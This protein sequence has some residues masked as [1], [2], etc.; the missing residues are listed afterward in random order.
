MTGFT[1]GLWA[2]EASGA[3]ALLRTVPEPEPYFLERRFEAFRTVGENVF[4]QE[5]VDY[6]RG[7]IWMTDG[8]VDG[9][10]LVSEAVEGDANRSAASEQSYFFASFGYGTQSLYSL[11]VD[12]GEVMLLGTWE[13]YFWEDL[14]LYSGGSSRVY[15]RAPSDSG[16]GLW[17]TDGTPEGTIEVRFDRSPYWT[18]S[19]AYV[20]F[21]DAFVFETLGGDEVPVL[22]EHDALE[23][24][25]QLLRMPP[26][27]SRPWRGPPTVLGDLLFFF[28]AEEGTSGHQLWRTDG[29]TAGTFQVSQFPV[30]QGGIGTG[31]GFDA[32]GIAVFVLDHYCTSIPPHCSWRNYV[33]DGSVE[34]SGL[35]EGDLEPWTAAAVP[36][37]VLVPGCIEG[38][39]T[40]LELA[41]IDREDRSVR[42]AANFEPEIGATTFKRLLAREG[43]LYLSTGTW[44]S[45]PLSWFLPSPL[46]EPI[47]S[48]GL[49]RGDAGGSGESRWNDCRERLLRQSTLHLGPERGELAPPS[50]VVRGLWRRAGEGRDSWRTRLPSRKRDQ[51]GGVGNE[52]DGRG[53]A[54]SNRARA[55][56]LR[57]DRRCLRLASVL[58]RA[59]QFLELVVASPV[60]RHPDSA[61]RRDGPAVL[62]SGA[63]S[64][65]DRES[66]LLHDARV[67]VVGTLAPFGRDSGGNRHHLDLGGERARARS[68]PGR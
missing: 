20:W 14:E 45:E 9:T 21:G 32:G 68:L 62:S 8:T 3:A 12:S 19:F 51:P 27:D 4:F 33:S 22:W 53:D 63:R 41:L 25:A 16:T 60:G 23:P 29:T 57:R 55:S 67:R 1:H 34:G 64:G 2:V 48:S 61:L 54:G 46:Q 6:S 13:A 11:N 31:S 35:V 39:P 59:I 28:V 30:G 5:V 50:P 47:A 43:E 17:V 37:G 66:P 44:W 65:H 42:V 36:A 26:P 15:F 40:G 18:E 7:R 49:R 58:P 10:R 56:A 52:R 24:S 38:C